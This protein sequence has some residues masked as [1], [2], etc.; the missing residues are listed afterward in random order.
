MNILLKSIQLLLQ[1]FIDHII[2]KKTFH[3]NLFF[4]ENWSN[5][6]N[7]VSYGHDIEAAWLL[8]EAAEIIKDE[9]LIK[10]IKELSIKMTDAS[11]EGLDKDDGLWYEIENNHLIKEKHWWPQAEAMI[12]FFDAYQLTGD[13]KYLQQSINSWLFIKTYLLDNKNG[14]WFWGVNE[15]YSIMQGNDKAGFWKCP[16]HNSR[17]CLEIIKRGNSILNNKLYEKNNGVNNTFFF[18]GI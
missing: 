3:L 15:D 4:D 5:K 16:Y 2:N 10:K 1:N 8:L 6:S 13:E 7:I 17:A 9:I 14:E 11:A 18:N 12:G